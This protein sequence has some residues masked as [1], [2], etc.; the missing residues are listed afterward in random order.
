MAAGWDVVSEYIDDCRAPLDRE[1]GGFHFRDVSVG[2]S[3]VG[4]EREHEIND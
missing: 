1:N 3:E 2:D 4:Q